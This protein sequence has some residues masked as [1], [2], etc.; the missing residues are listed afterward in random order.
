MPEGPAPKV[1]GRAWRGDEFAVSLAGRSAHTRDAYEHDVAEFV[2]WAER[3]GCPAPSAIDHRTLRRYLAYLDTRGFARALD[4]PQGRRA[5]RL[6]A[7]PPAPRCDRPRP[8]SHPAGPEGRRPAA[9]GHPQRRGRRPAR[10]R[11]RGRRPRPRP[12][13]GRSRRHRGGAPRPRRARGAL[14]RRAAG[15]RV[16]RA[17]HRRLRPRPRPGHRAGQ[18]VEGA[19]GPDRRA[20]GRRARRLA[21]P[22]PRRARRP[23]TS[24]TDAVFLNRRGRRCSR[25]GTPAGSSSG[26]RCPTGARS[27]RMRSATPTLRTCS[28]A[29][30][31]SGQ[32][33][34]SSATP[35]S[36]PPRSTP[37]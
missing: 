9:S 28:K 5:A 14:R 19:T 29:E 23:P 2:A 18:G 8:R 13:G 37:T 6:P 17:A 15:R 30:P 34:S 3:G 24:P 12:G 20:G 10:R 32:C 26:I 7:L 36:P 35:I 1:G 11:L 31:T 25:R 22:G 33:R 4:R 16:L 27:T 21:R